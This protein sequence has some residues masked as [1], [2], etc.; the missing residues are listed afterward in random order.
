[1]LRKF[2]ILSIFI[3]LLAPGA[4][5][6][7]GQVQGF[8]IGSLNIV[9]RCGP[10]GSAQGGNMV[11][12][13]QGQDLQKYCPPMTAKQQQGGMLVQCG[14]AQGRR[15]VSGVL[16][17]AKVQGLQGQQIKP[18]GSSLQGQSLDVKLGQIALKHR[19]VGL[20]QGTQS[21]IGGQNQTIS[22]PRMTSTESQLVGVGQYANISGGPGSSALVVNSVDVKMGQGQSVTTGPIYKPYAK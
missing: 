7:I 4:F 6:D 2:L 8:S 20:T 17:S 1:M 9:A 12:V 3:L 21:F 10:V 5:A 14:T 11:M 19:G 22:T 18:F 13:G 15:G 16:N